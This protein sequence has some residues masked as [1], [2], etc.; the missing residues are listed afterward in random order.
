MNFEQLIQKLTEIKVSAGSCAES[1]DSPEFDW[2][3]AIEADLHEVTKQLESNKELFS[4]KQMD[5]VAGLLNRVKERDETIEQLRECGETGYEVAP[6]KSEGFL[7]GTAHPCGCHKC[8]E[9][10]RKQQPENPTL[11]Y[12]LMILCS[13]CG[14]KRCP[15]AT[16]HELECTSSNDPGQKGSAYE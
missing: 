14:N 6:T 5:I 12:R 9:A 10:L 4:E 2:F 15:H 13:K 16:D 1:A 11:M 7:K 8:T 3:L